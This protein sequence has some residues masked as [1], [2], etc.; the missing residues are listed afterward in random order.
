MMDFKGIWGTRNGKKA[1]VESFGGDVWWSKIDE[2][3]YC[4]NRNGELDTLAC[5]I[6][7]AARDWDLMERLSGRWSKERSGGE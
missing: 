7:G 6:E 2:K 3:S 4:W 1:E 5:D